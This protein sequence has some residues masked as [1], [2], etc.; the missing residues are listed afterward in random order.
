M[1]ERG[2][3]FT[4]CDI[5]K[6]DNRTT[7]VVGDEWM[8]YG[9]GHSCR[10]R[11]ETTKEGDPLSSYRLFIVCQKNDLSKI[12]LRCAPQRIRVNVSG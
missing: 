6:R 3:G 5:L 1:D 10:S 7:I 8:R 12:S 9:Q 11:T 4:E 2:V